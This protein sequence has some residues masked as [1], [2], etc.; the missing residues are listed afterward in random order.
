MKKI[1]LVKRMLALLAAVF[2]AFASMPIIPIEASEIIDVPEMNETSKKVKKPETVDTYRLDIKYDT[3][4]GSIAVREVQNDTKSDISG[5]AMEGGATY[6]VEEGKKYEVEVSANEGYQIDSVPEGFVKEEDGEHYTYTIE[7]AESDCEY[8][9]SFKEIVN[10]I[11]V[12]VAGNGKVVYDFGGANQRE[13]GRI[14]TENCQSVGYK[15]DAEFTLIPDDGRY[16]S[17]VEIN[18]QSI[19]MDDAQVRLADDG[20]SVYTFKSVTNE[21]IISVTFSEIQTEYLKLQDDETMEE[22]LNRGHVDLVFEKES[23]HEKISV[24][25]NQIT[26]TLTHH[27]KVSVTARQDENY[28]YEIFNDDKYV[29]SYDISASE[30]GLFQRY[31][32]RRTSGA[33]LDSVVCYSTDCECNFV[34]DNVKPEVR[35]EGTQTVWLGPVNAGN[36]IVIN[37]EASDA[38]TGIQAVVCYTE[39]QDI[40]N[41]EDTITADAV[42]VALV[43]DGKYSITIGDAP[44]ENTT[45]YVYA[46][47]NAQNITETAVTYQWD[48]TAP[49]VSIETE[50]VTSFWQKLFL[51][52][53]KIEVIVTADDADGSGVET[54][55]LLVNGEEYQTKGCNENGK[56]TFIVMLKAGEEHDFTAFATD[57]VGNKTA[58]DSVAD[59][60]TVIYDNVAPH[61]N[62]SWDSIMEENVPHYCREDMAMN[63]SVADVDS[64]LADIN[65]TINGK[66]ITTDVAGKNIDTDY[67]RLDETTKADDF[68]LNTA[69]GTADEN[70]KYVVKIEVNDVAGNTNEKTYV[71]YKDEDA[72]KITTL[73]VTGKNAAGEAIIA[74]GSGVSV[75]ES[76]LIYGYYA[77]DELVVKVAA[78]DGAYGSGVAEINYVLKNADGTVAASDTVAMSGRESYDITIPADFKGSIYVKAKDCV[79]NEMSEYVTTD[80]MIAESELRFDA[81]TH[82][83][84]TTPETVTKDADGYNLYADSVTIPV[85]VTDSYA[86]IRSIEW[87]VNAP[88]DSN[89][90]QSGRVTVDSAGNISEGGWSVKEKDS[91]LA[92]RVE[93]AVQVNSNSNAISVTVKVTNRVGYVSVQNMILS[94]DKTA[95]VMEIRFDKEQGD[96][97]YP[98]YFAENRTAIITIKERNFDETKVNLNVANT[99]G[100]VPTISGWTSSGTGDETVYT[101]ELEFSAD[102]DYIVSMQFTDRA[103]NQAQPLD[104][105]EFTIDKT[106]PK[107]EVNFDNEQ[108]MNGNYFNAERTATIQVDEHNF[109]AERIEIVGKATDNGNN[110]TFPVTGSWSDS[111]D[112]HTAT[113]HFNYDGEFTFSVDGLDMAGNEA[114][115]VEVK[116]YVI[117]LT[118]PV[119]EIYGVENM[120]ANNG[121]VQPILQ[122]MDT[123]YSQ[124]DVEIELVGA[125]RG[126]VAVE[127]AFVDSENGQTFRF[128]DFANEQEVDDIYTLTA[129]ETDMAGNTVSESITFSVNRFG[130]VYTLDSGLEEI[131]GTYIQEAVDVVL[132]ET[133]VD[134]LDES[135]IEVVVS[136]NG[137]PRTLERGKDYTLIPSGA[138][139]SWKQYEY[140][141]HKENFAGDGTYKVTIYSVDA[142]GNINE[143][144]DETKKAEIEFGVDGTAPVIVPLNVEDGGSYDMN[145]MTASFSVQDN[146]VLEN[147]EIAL[148]GETVEYQSNG[149]IYE[150]VIPEDSKRQMVAVS[151]QDAAGNILTYEVTEVLVST[152]AL[153]RWYNNK[154]LF[155][156]TLAGTGAAVSGVGVTFGLR[157]K[158]YI[159]IK[160]K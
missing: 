90:N 125:N 99:E 18:G 159:R 53:N 70:G 23:D 157:R 57:K 24:N 151:A 115:T 88:Q 158:N 55:T 65:V 98:D 120:S 117:D 148:N 112:T 3:A 111:G 107:I 6:V 49:D 156:G 43:E 45:Y 36:E 1:G 29:K 35:I 61:I 2:I 80:R 16:V 34:I 62:S 72:P 54:V 69:Q 138:S 91:N 118:E 105:K 129:A 9:F 150:F 8:A 155:A 147:V 152:N 123:N 30:Q 79:G 20:N 135:S 4:C 127:G 113:L 95:P 17:A 103:G 139:G 37:G 75:T 84:M 97:A 130:S 116:E 124:G 68:V 132:T 64:G 145:Q 94:I 48:R 22:M 133:N 89:T 100:S 52:R 119:I 142:A 93:G 58:D 77:A 42:Y 27:K 66:V 109:D 81:E 21:Q 50:N 47:D 86:G 40:C 63:L 44:A 101:T 154:P 73:Q 102:G 87:S 110:I 39:Q 78:S 51:N 160:R 104:K 140:N 108:S 33:W 128:S 74:E 56:C 126:A 82:I 10:N 71:V 153:V 60:G 31:V 12:D 14:A 146:L 25:D 67:T 106:L 121:T 149:D 141:L 96:V 137:I 85:V 11:T 136:A 143:T 41:A 122:I 15:D 28:I 46:V 19:D 92:I 83:M 26:Y 134:L 114:E 144:V 7:E 32:I 5:S 131:T 59:G 76:G 13:F 38:D